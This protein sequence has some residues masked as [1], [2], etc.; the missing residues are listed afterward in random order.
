MSEL[1]TE[2]EA[3]DAAATN[4]DMQALAELQ[5]LLE[6]DFI[7]LLEEF[8]NISEEGSAELIAH[9]AQQNLD[10]LRRG[11]HSLKGSALNIG[12]PDLG[13]RWSALEDAAV[14]QAASEVLESLLKQA[15]VALEQTTVAL[16]SHFF[17][18]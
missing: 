9:V 11:A 5:E 7:G 4:L 12:A 14:E 18:A 8:I 16:R 1:S 2:Q 17:S 3:V 6:E 10:E 15:Q 13:S